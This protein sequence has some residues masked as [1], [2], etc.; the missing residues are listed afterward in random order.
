MF[1]LALAKGLRPEEYLALQLKDIDFEKQTATVSRALVYLPKIGLQFTEPKTKQSRRTIPLP[2]SLVNELRLHRKKQLEERLKLGSIW[3]NYDLVFP[4]M[5]GNPITHRY[6]TDIFKRVL[7][8]AKLRTTLR[9]Y[10][11]RHTH[12]TLLLKAGVHAKIV[13]ERLGHSTIASTLDVLF[14]RLAKYASRSR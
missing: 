11:L 6:I 2:N 4:S 9:L 3:G 10:D 7:K 1:S 12:A 14:S 13:S 5:V 8:N